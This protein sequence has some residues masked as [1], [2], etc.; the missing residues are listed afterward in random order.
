VGYFL[1][2]IGGALWV[3]FLSRLIDGFTGGNIATAMAY[4]ADVTPPKDRARNFAFGGVAFGL[5]FIIGP[6][7][8]GALSTISLAAP[9]FAAG[10]LSLASFLFGL[11]FLPESLPSEKRAVGAFHLREVNPFRVIAE[12]GR[13]PNLGLLLSAIFILY[14]A[15]SGLF[16]FVTVYT[17]NRFS[18][19]P[20]ENA[21]LFMVIGV[22]QMVGQGGIVYRL[23]PRFGEKRIAVFGLF[24]QALTYPLFVIVPGFA[25]LYPL[26]VVSALGNALT[27]PTLDALVANSVAA[28]EQGRAAGTTS[29]LYSL[30]NMIGPLAA[31]L[32]YDTVSPGSIFLVGGALIGLACLIVS[33]VRTAQPVPALTD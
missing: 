17:L 32:L 28:H 29:A 21:A 5:G 27:R 15:Y 16:G 12:M 4:I 6:V 18:A 26:A 2:G 8:S 9:A 13:L 20:Q 31:G 10:G 14:L 1:F 3:L 19:T 23:T 22:F 33:Q 25:Y 24:L 30:T 11:V 7:I